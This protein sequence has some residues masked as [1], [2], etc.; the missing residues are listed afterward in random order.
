MAGQCFLKH[1]DLCI[2]LTNLMRMLQFGELP[3][4]GQ[5]AQ[6][7]R[8]AGTLDPAP[9]RPPHPLPPLSLVD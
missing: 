9:T 2:N 3:P 4:P 6:R 5:A 8:A 7:G 1:L